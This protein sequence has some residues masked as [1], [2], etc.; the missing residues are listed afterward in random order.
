MRLRRRIFDG[1]MGSPDFGARRSKIDLTAAV[2]PTICCAVSGQDQRSNAI[3]TGSIQVRPRLFWHTGKC[4]APRVHAQSASG[5]V[6]ATRRTAAGSDGLH[7]STLTLARVLPTNKLS[8]PSLQRRAARTRV[9]IRGWGGGRAQKKHVRQSHASNRD[10]AGNTDAHR[11]RAD[12]A[13]RI[14]VSA[15]QPASGSVAAQAPCARSHTRTVPSLEHE[16]PN[17]RPSAPRG[18]RQHELAA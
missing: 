10:L 3:Y 13:H 15:A 16:A 9:R 5:C 2:R 12:G 1:L 11:C 18:S 8:V 7:C 17:S 4:A 14:E 6:C